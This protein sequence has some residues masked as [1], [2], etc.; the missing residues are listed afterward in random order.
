M[1]Q[2]MH[3]LPSGYEKV[4]DLISLVNLLPKLFFLKIQNLEFRIL[5]IAFGLRLQVEF[6]NFQ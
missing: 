5:L 1:R 2:I 4:A 6:L 3:T